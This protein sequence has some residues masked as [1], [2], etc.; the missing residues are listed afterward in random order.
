MV[1][2]LAGASAEDTIA[3]V[4][5]VLVPM[6]TPKARQGYYKNIRR[7]V[8]LDGRVSFACALCEL[9]DF[10]NA[11]HAQVHV[12]R[13]HLGKRQN[14]HSPGKK[15]GKAVTDVDK[16]M[17][18]VVTALEQLSAAVNKKKDNTAVDAS[19]RERALTAERKLATLRRTLGITD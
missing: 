1:A 6:K 15:T 19:W 18:N 14:Q 17:V 11:Q 16:A 7:V 13:D 2:E 9:K 8:W 12:S 4:E 3:M 5:R 10:R